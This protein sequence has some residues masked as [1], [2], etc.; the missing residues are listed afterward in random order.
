MKKPI[1]RPRVI[2]FDFNGTMVNDFSISY[3]SVIKIFKNFKLIPPTEEEFRNGISTDFMKFYHSRGIPKEITAEDLNIHRKNIFRKNIDQLELRDGLISI[4]DICD[5]FNIQK[6]I[7][8][9]ED[10]E[11]LSEMLKKFGMKNR[12]DYIAPDVKDKLPHI[13]KVLKKTGVAPK[14][15][16]LI[17]D[18]KDGLLAGNRAK[19]W[20]VGFPH[21]YNPR[22][23]VES[24]SP[25]F[26][27]ENLI[28]VLKLFPSGR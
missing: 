11:L 2:I 3:L 21:G 5:E 24:A 16:V 14:Q 12:F 26:I 25:S 19:V 18:S 13:L 9:A 28:D 10:G 8:S 4:L 6:V 22:E 23:M 27:I 7:I 17:D 20:T 15:V 1:R